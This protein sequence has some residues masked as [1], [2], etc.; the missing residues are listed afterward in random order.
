[1]SK[2]FALNEMSNLCIDLGLHNLVDRAST[3]AS[4]THSTF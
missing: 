2:P 3:A 4:G 1:M